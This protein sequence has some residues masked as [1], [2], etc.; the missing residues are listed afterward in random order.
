MNANSDATTFESLQQGRCWSDAGFPRE[1]MPFNSVNASTR[2]VQQFHILANLQIDAACQGCVPLIA[3]LVFL[4]FKD[5]DYLSFCDI[6]PF[7]QM[8][9]CAGLHFR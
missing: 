7:P 5:L 8:H 4:A 2:C 6:A 9:Q 3:A 1:E